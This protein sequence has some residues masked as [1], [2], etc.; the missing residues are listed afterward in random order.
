MAIQ[1][2]RTGRLVVIRLSDEDLFRASIEALERLA[3]WLGIPEPKK[4]NSEKDRRAC[5][6][7]AIQRYEKRVGG[8]QGP[9]RRLDLPSERRG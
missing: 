1:E 3:R 7:R 5:I 9:R 6:V 8:R 2:L 4:Y